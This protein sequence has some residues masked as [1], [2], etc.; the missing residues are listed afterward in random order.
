[1]P[2][3]FDKQLSQMSAEAL[4][5]RV[6]HHAW[7]I[8]TLDTDAGFALGLLCS[9]CGAE[10]DKIRDWRGRARRRMWYGNAHGYLFTGTGRLSKEQRRA[11]EDALV[12]E[13]DDGRLPKRD[14]S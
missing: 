6:L 9:R 14:V 1:M 5:C 11:I 10:A 7:T 13:L 12:T 3:S 8:A 4:M 2:D